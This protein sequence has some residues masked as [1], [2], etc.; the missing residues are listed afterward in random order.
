[1]IYPLST[2]N[3]CTTSLAKVSYRFTFSYSYLL[4][5]W[6]NIFLAIIAICTQ[7]A[8]YTYNKGRDSVVAV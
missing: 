8:P 2:L 7:D 3:V 6:L 5:G 4:E 1:M